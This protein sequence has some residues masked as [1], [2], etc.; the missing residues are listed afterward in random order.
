LLVQVFTSGQGQ[1][2]FLADPA[3]VQAAVRWVQGLQE[4][5]LTDI[6]TPLIKAVQILTAAR[7]VPYIFLITDGKL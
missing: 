3:V 5:G 7:G 2:L 6:Q 1:T 4:G